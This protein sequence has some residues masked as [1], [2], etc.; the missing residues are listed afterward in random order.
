MVRQR[1]RG[2]NRSWICYLCLKSGFGSSFNGIHFTVPSS[3]GAT[4][5]FV[6]CSGRPSAPCPPP[7]VFWCAALVCAPG[8]SCRPVCWH[9]LYVIKKRKPLLQS[10]C[11]LG[12]EVQVKGNVPGLWAGVHTQGYLR[13]HTRGYLHVHTRGYPRVHTRGYLRVHTVIPTCTHTGIPT[14]THTGIPT[15]VRVWDQFGARWKLVRQL[16]C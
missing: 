13:V 8:V 16:H 10:C 12:D 14:C 11:V 5:G 1:D 2:F 4:G 15:W 3:D 9:L 7:P 6:K